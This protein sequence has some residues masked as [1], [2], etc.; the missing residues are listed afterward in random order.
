MKRCHVVPLSS[1]FLT[2]A[3]YLLVLLAVVAC[4]EGEAPPPP[5]EPITVKEFLQQIDRWPPAINDRGPITVPGGAG[6]GCAL[7][8][9]P[10]CSIGHPR[11]YYACDQ[12][13]LWVG[14]A[15]V[16]SGCWNVGDYDCEM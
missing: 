8:M 3:V 10:H 16:P 14:A 1:L 9:D 2:A 12:D 4:G 5:S 13:Y 15:P 7:C 6:Y 11:G